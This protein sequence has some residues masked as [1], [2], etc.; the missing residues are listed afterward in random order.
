MGAGLELC[1][2]KDGL[3]RL[4][5]QP[6]PPSSPSADFTAPPH[7]VYGLL[8]K[9]AKATSILGVQAMAPS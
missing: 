5:L 4:N 1:V 7:P 2:A 6:L 3:E 8:G 9:E